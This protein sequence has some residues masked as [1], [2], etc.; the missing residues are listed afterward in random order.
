MDTFPL[1]LSF[2]VRMWR[3]GSDDW[4]GEVEH[5]QSGRRWEFSTAEELCQFLSDPP[6]RMD[7]GEDTKEDQS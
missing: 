6:N 2:L 3:E 4:Q 1:Y 7:C 5:I